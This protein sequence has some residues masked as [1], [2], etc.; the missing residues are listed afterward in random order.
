MEVEPMPPAEAPAPFMAASPVSQEAQRVAGALFDQASQRAFI[1]SGGDMQKAALHF[2][3][4]MQADA[5]LRDAVMVLTVGAFLAQ[6]K[7]WRKAGRPQR[8]RTA[9]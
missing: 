9:R 6:P 8:A 5:A 3:S 1:A 2:W 7:A 4:A